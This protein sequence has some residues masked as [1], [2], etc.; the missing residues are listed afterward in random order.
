M[1]GWLQRQTSSAFST[2]FRRRYFEIVFGTGKIYI[3]HN[4][5]IPNEISEK[6]K[7]LN[8]RDIKSTVIMIGDGNCP[9]DSK[10]PF[11]VETTGKP[12]VLFA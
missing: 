8:F 4:S 1:S 5:G 6:C 9:E 10:F 2:N 12:F 7:V 3:K 11:K